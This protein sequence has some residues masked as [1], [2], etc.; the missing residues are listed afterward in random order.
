M[1]FQSPKTGDSFSAGLDAAWPG[2][3]FQTDAN[4]THDWTWTV[5]WGT[6]KKNG[7]VQTSGNSWDAGP[8]VADAGGIL[9]V[10]ASAG[11]ENA[12]I[13]VKIG[14]TNPTPAAAMAYLAGKSGADGFDKILQHESKFRQFTATGEPLKSFDNGYGMCQLTTP[15]PTCEQVWNWQRNIDGG[16]ALFAAKMAAATKYLSQ[17]GRTFTPEQLKY[18]AVC[19]WNGGAYHVWDAA[20]NK[21]VRNPNILCD[22]TTGSIGWDMTDPANAGKS[23]QELHS[24]D[25]GSYSKPPG[26]GAHWKYSGICYADAI[27]G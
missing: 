20:A 6:F 21:W 24:R 3:V 7:A 9:T 4:G 25:S 18:E 1:K 2:I 15:A 26:A 10:T 16:L 22:R 19:R 23:A 17:S 27:L 8:A 14:G 11:G 12:S 5:Q 13:T